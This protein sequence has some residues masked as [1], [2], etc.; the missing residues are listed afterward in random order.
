YL[1]T[2]GLG[3]LGLA[4]ARWLAMAGARRIVL[5]GRSGLPPR[6]QWRRLDPRS[7]D[8]RR[9]HAILAL[10][11]LGAGIQIARVDVSDEAALRAWLA[12]YRD[13]AFPPIRGV[14]HEAGELRGGPIASASAEDFS[15]ELAPKV[16]GTWALVQALALAGE[17]LDQVVLFSSASA[18]LPSPGLAGYAAGNSFLDA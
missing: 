2:G 4:T 1:V 14:F 5:M 12:R 7:R 9:A 10:E 11:A 13:E 16:A 6:A 3:E 18:V 15:P 17:P 8:G